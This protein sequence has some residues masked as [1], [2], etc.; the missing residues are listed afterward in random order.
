MLLFGSDD[1]NYG[2]QANFY[3]GVDNIK[4]SDHDSPFQ[5]QRSRGFVFVV[6]TANPKSI[7]RIHRKT[8]DLHHLEPAYAN[9][10]HA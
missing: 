5:R 4:Q 6:A 3:G 2:S 9:V 1:S 10:Y 8:I 7:G